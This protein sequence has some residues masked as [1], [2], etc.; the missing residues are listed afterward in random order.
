MQGRSEE[1]RSQRDPPSLSA[2]CQGLLPPPSHRL[3]AEILFLYGSAS[4][5]LRTDGPHVERDLEATILLAAT[6][7][8]A[9]MRRGYQPRTREHGALSNSVTPSLRRHR[10]CSPYGMNVT[11]NPSQESAW[12]MAVYGHIAK[13]ALLRKKRDG[14]DM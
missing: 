5:D 6:M 3:V 1:V 9:Q 2:R 14:I 13:L 10:Q 7:V 11:P 12:R 8:T 4:T